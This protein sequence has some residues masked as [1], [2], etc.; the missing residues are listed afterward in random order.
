MLGD[1]AFCG[2]RS[3][4]VSWRRMQRFVFD[5]D[6]C[7]SQQEIQDTSFGHHKLVDRFPT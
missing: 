6:P 7:D 5:R 3:S 4:D 2:D 1:S